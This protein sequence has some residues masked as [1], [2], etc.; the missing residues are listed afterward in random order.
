MNTLLCKAPQRRHQVRAHP[1]INGLDYLET[2][3]ESLT[4]TV[5]FLGKAPVALQAEN[6]VIEG[7]RRISNIKV[8]SVEVFPTGTPELDDFMVVQIDKFGDF[9]TYTLRIVEKDAQQQLQPHSAFDRRYDRVAFS[10]K[11][12]CTDGLDC[13]PSNACPLQQRSEPNIN[14]LAK[15]YAS[16]RQLM[17]DRLSLLM[18]GWNERHVPDIGVA[19]VEVLAYVGDHLSYYQDAVATEAYLDTARQRISVRRHARLVDYTLNEGCNARTWIC[20]QTANDLS[21]AAQDISFITRLPQLPDSFEQSALHEIPN[22]AYE[23]FEPVSKTAAI[24][25]Y[26]GQHAMPF[27]TWGDHECCLLKG[28][29]SAT[30]QGQWQLQAGEVLILEEAI[31]PTT[32]KA[33]DADLKHRH[34]VLLTAVTPNIDPLFPEQPLTDIS[35]AAEDALPFPLCLSALIY[36]QTDAS[37]TA[38]QQQQSLTPPHPCQRVEGISFARGNLILVD[39]G[40]TI[41]NEVL[42][43]VE[44][45]QTTPQCLDVGVLT[46]VS[47]I[48]KPYQAVLQR[49][50]LV[51]SQP[52]A[53]STAAKHM[54]QQDERLALPAVHLAADTG[55]IWQVRADLLASHAHEAHV[56]V[57]MAN[58]GQAHLRFGDGELGKQPIAGTQFFASYRIGR[59]DAGNVG[60]N[61]IRHLVTR[62]LSLSGASIQ[63]HNLLP[64]VGGKLPEPLAQAKLFAPHSFRNRLE[65]AITAADYV[66]IVERDFP[67]QVQHAVARIDWTGS[68]YQVVVAVDAV[69]SHAADE[70]LLQAI[71]AHLYRYRRIGH[72]VVV[73]AARTIALYIGLKVCVADA[74]LQGQVKAA[75]LQA[76]SNRRLPDGSLGFFHP[77]RL[78][79]GED[80]HLSKL[81]AAAHAVTEVESVV[82]TQCQRLFDPLPSNNEALESGVLAL[83]LFEIARLDNDPSMPENGKLDLFMEGGR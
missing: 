67:A 7:G 50:P 60:A 3:L 59:G 64:A 42:P 78:S 41:L 70:S 37:T 49:A 17:F 16:F 28:A 39:H 57:E 69:G 5:F 20:V 22:S 71:T 54:L 63:V 61:S 83:E 77:D 27:Y 73:K 44:S 23:V 10:F 45:G 11:A 56:V 34:P 62:N 14:Y 1:H 80:I 32:G 13:R 81:V 30:L 65:R 46:E 8:L 55:E 79:F 74:Y 58:D 6:V 82:V 25:L 66:A 52:W 48:Q 72:D 24:Q 4:L 2:D 76:F 26:A 35:W 18:P 9:S 36:Q 43:V 53:V 68:R 29:T 47:T 12:D 19:L 33:Q 15:D 38:Q 31:S 51:F 21:L 75:L 40:S